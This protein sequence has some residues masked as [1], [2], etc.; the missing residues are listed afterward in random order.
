MNALDPSLAETA[1]PKPAGEAG[2]VYPKAFFAWSAVVLLTIAYSLSLLD[3]WVLTLLVGPVK[4]ALHVSDT[5]MGLLMG[6]IFAL[7]YVF[8]G[9]PS[10]WI[11][12]RSNRRN[13]AATAIAFWCLMTVLS[14]FAGSFGTLALCRF[15]IGFGEAALTPA[16]TSM[17]ADLFPR[18]KVNS[19]LGVFNLGVF[20]GMGL[21]YLIGGALLGWA[22]T[23]GTQV[24]HG[25]L[26]SW[27]IVFLLVGAPGFL[28]AA[29]LF[30]GVREP[31]RPA[32]HAASQASMRS[33]LD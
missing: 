4:A 18:H 20:S 21:S 29:M 30:F 8:L 22:T 26:Q 16:A 23:Q 12:D 7:V 32:G 24:F 27:Q 25:H 2:R 28:V 9:L 10:G 31:K 5:A 6:P 14:G 19:A 3:R 1:A 11:A 17:I 13:L 33:C 15:G